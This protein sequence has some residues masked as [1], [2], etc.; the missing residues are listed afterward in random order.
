MGYGLHIP[1]ARRV[2]QYYCSFRGCSL[3]GGALLMGVL[4]YLLLF[5]LLS[6]SLDFISYKQQLQNVFH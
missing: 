5:M 4:S 3:E 2:V 6:D 1:L